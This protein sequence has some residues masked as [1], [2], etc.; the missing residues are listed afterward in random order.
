[1]LNAKGKTDVLVRMGNEKQT[2][3]NSDVLLNNFF[4]TLKRK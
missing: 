1:M 3:G 2:K 4:Y